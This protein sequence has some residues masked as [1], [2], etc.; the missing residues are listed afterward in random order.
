MTS[1]QT[2]VDYN[3]F[4]IIFYNMPQ[5]AWRIFQDMKTIKLEKSSIWFKK[6]AYTFKHNRYLLYRVIVIFYYYIR[7]LNGHLNNV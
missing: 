7:R 3:I 5:N 6:S 2:N 4:V 1:F